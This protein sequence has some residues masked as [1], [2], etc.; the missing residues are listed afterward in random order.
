MDVIIYPFWI[1]MPVKEVHGVATMISYDENITSIKFN[2]LKKRA[3]MS[4]LSVH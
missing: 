3:Q 4:S 2:G 1:T